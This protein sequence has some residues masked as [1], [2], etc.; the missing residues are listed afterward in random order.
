MT[1]LIRGQVEAFT[2]STAGFPLGTHPWYFTGRSNCSDPGQPWRTLNL[3]PLVDQPGTFCCQDGTCLASSESVCDM[4]RDCRDGSDEVDCEMV[5]LAA[6]Y[7]K[8][9]PPTIE[10]V[11]QV[12]A[13]V[14]IRNIIEIDRDQ[15]SMFVVFFLRLK[16][17][18]PQIVFNFLKEDRHKNSINVETAERIWIPG[19]D[20]ITLISN[21]QLNKE[22]SVV[23]EA[24]PNFDSDSLVAKE[25]YSSNESM[26]HK[27]TTNYAKFL[28]PF[29]GNEN[30]PFGSS[31]ICR[32]S[33][34]ISG[35]DNYLTELVSD[36]MIDDGPSIVG[37]YK[38]LKWSVQS[39]KVI[40]TNQGLQY[41]VELARRNLLSIIMSNYLPSFLM[42]M[43]NQATNYISSSEKYELVITVNIT[44]MMVL[45]QIYLAISSTLPT[46]SFL[47]PVEIF[48][49]SSL[50]YPFLVIVINILIQVSLY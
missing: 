45:A 31:Q 26:I 13:E 44:S 3:H 46:S 18:D 33:I 19:L 7:N 48:L 41:T 25:W 20:F 10:T 40:G 17:R 23:K 12:K 8:R 6:G 32:F 50:I 36:A 47:T 27:S 16:W 4:R 15:N 49:L 29:T 42:N 11:M 28:C 14:I 21:T 24:S 35:S 38:V 2:T 9:T 37:E 22:T 30:Y 34:M 1:N 39:T 5:E 43:I